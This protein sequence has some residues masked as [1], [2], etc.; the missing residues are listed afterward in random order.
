MNIKKEKGK[1]EI[2][3]VGSNSN[4]DLDS[5]FL[6]R[7]SADIRIILNR[8]SVLFHIFSKQIIGQYF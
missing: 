3:E 5:K 6:F 1:Q 4:P 7:I 2:K 8:I